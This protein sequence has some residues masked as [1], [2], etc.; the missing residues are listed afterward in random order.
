MT[1]VQGDDGS[2]GLVDGDS[3]APGFFLLGSALDSVIPDWRENGESLPP[4]VQDLLTGGR[5]FVAEEQDPVE[6]AFLRSAEIPIAGAV[7]IDPQATLTAATFIAANEDPIRVAGVDTAPVLIP[8]PV[9]SRFWVLVPV[10]VLVPTVTIIKR[11][12]GPDLTQWLI[13]AMK[14]ISRG[15]YSA[16]RLVWEVIPGHGFDYKLEREKITKPED[17]DCPIECPGCITICEKCVHISFLG[18]FFLGYVSAR[19]LGRDLGERVAISISK[20]GALRDLGRGDPEYDEP[21][22][23]AA[24]AAGLDLEGSTGFR[25]F[26]GSEFGFDKENVCS[27][28]KFGPNPY[29]FQCSCQPCDCPGTLP[30]P[31]P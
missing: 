18:N 29:I 17:C 22:D 26:S 4:E 28:I 2:V 20:G 21:E 11:I 14:S 25:W 8:I 13:D 16:P 31:K 6:G 1:G 30:L 19:V 23:E 12:C 3:S 9:M 24:A 15:D 5:G 10:T 27:K 7:A